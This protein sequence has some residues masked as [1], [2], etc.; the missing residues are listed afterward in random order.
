MIALLRKLLPGLLP[1]LV[2]VAADEIFGT[3]IGLAV[4]VGFGMVQLVFIRIQSKKWDRFVI[5]DTLLLVILGG[6]SI[7]LDNE[8]LFLWKPALIEMILAGFIGISV[9][10]KH[11]LMLLMSK[12][13]M[14]EIEIGEA[15]MKQFN[16]SMRILFFITLFHIGLSIYSIYFL[17][18]EWW[19]F[20]SGVLFYILAAVY[21]LFEFLRGRLNMKKNDRE[22]VPL[23]DEKGKIIG[24]A[25]RA[26]VHNGSHQLHPVVHL[27]V[28][29]QRGDFLLQKRPKNKAIQPGKWDT[30]VGGHVAFGES[31]EKS[32]MREAKEEI[33]ISG[34]KAYPIKQYVWK[35]EIESEL[36]FVFVWQAPEGTKFKHTDEVDELRWWS[37]KEINKNMGKDIFTPNFEQEYILVSGILKQKK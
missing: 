3:R 34:F 2:F 12:R 13:Y 16:R 15:Q 36:I 22:M 32:L 25:P 8:I 37:M 21:F 33:G 7:L 11:N 1:L 5:F 4:A 9:F 31:I 29:N 27:H 10:S 30:S 35:S 6:V 19:G 17:S 20:I 26:E 23:V 24:R 28:I 18:K 14:G